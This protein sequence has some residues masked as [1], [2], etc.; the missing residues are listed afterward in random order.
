MV[1]GFFKIFSFSL[2]FFFLFLGALLLMAVDSLKDNEPLVDVV[3][4][5]MGSLYSALGKFEKSLLA[6]RRSIDVL[7]NR[8]GNWC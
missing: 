6:Y 4:V 1:N 2:N 7:E 5:H 8:H 3:L